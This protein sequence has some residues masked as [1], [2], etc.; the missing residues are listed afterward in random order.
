MIKN[1]GTVIHF[2]NPKVQASLSANTFAVTGHA[3]NKRKLFQV[4]ICYELFVAL[5]SV[6]FIKL[7]KQVFTCLPLEASI[8]L[9]FLVLY[10]QT[11][12]LL[13]SNSLSNFFLWR[14]MT[15]SEQKHCIN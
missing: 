14:C 6:V 2:N 5:Y 9:L 12:S 15:F 1:D 11:A 3:E 13:L 10:Y 7:G 8:G 4:Y